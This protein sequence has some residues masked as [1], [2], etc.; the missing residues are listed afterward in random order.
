M[1]RST[2][3]SILASTIAL[4]LSTGI[5]SAEPSDT[6]L[7]GNADTRM[8]ATIETSIFLNRHLNPFEIDAD[9]QKGTAYLRGTVDEAVDKD[10]AE[11]IARSVDG[12]TSVKN[13]I[14][15]E[16]NY[17][18][19]KRKGPTLASRIA[20]ATTTASVKSRL[21]WN[22]NT[23]GLD[24]DVD[25]MQGMVTLQGTVR[26]AAESELATKIAENTSGVRAVKNKLAVASEQTPKAKLGTIDLDKTKDNAASAAESMGE[27]VSDAWITSKAGSA[28]FFDQ[29]VHSQNIDV[30]TEQAVVTLRGSV[31]TSAEKAL[32]EEIVSDLVGV[33]SVENELSVGKAS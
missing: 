25:T 15:V 20:D 11:E 18:A 1:N 24:I 29:A 28:L 30:D 6:T 10:L 9:V 2:N 27:K 33:K 32:A 26:S 4:G 16:K 12:V 8:E 17:E 3:Y 5:A 7:M 22:R 31:P 14:V 21:L 23:H 13:E 19:P